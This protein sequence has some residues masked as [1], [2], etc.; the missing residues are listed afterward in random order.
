VFGRGTDVGTD[1]IDIIIPEKVWKKAG[2]S[3]EGSYF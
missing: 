2:S 3:I 1:Y